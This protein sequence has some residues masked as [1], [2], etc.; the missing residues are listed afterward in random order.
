MHP[1]FI[2]ALT[3]SVVMAV[4][5]LVVL[6][7]GLPV[8]ITAPL[9]PLGAA[10]DRV[11]LAAG[12]LDACPTCGAVAEELGRQGRRRWLYCPACGRNPWLPGAPG[13][14]VPEEAHDVPA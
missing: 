4:L 5:L 3:F 2:L 12:L 7:L 11:A 6:L 13:E 8:R 1:D 10:L 9:R 14:S